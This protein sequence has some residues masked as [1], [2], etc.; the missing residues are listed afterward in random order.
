MAIKENRKDQKKTTTKA[1]RQLGFVV[2]GILMG[3]MGRLKLGFGPI[4]YLF[5]GTLTGLL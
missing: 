5:G 3:I 4:R 2:L 1:S